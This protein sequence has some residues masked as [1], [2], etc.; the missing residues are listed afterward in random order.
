MKG[1]VKFRPLRVSDFY[2]IELQP[3]HA[4]AKPMFQAN[5]LLLHA[6]TESPFSFTMTVDGKPVAALGPTANREW[7]AYLGCDLKRSMV[8]LVRYT[9]AMADMYG[10]LWS[11]VDRT[12][13]EGERFMLLLGLRKVKVAEEG[14]LD[15][16][17]R[18]NAS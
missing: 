17:I 11:R 1:K 7:W 5:P 14:V 16:W 15:T 18:G 9:N 10:P 8:R 12:N 6:L 13:P 4:E 2:E 3:R